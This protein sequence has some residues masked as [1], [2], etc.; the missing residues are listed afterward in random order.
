[1]VK[2][3]EKA[4]KIAN[5]NIVS[6]IVSGIGAAYCTHWFTKSYREQELKLL[7]KRNEELEQ[8]CTQYRRDNDQLLST[9]A[10]IV[11][12]YTIL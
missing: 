7:T 3:K 9:N 11:S 5:T 10:R 12:E 1:M 6:G 4:W 8:D 2:M